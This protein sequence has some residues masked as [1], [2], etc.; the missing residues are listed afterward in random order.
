MSSGSIGTLYEKL[1]PGPGRSAPK[2]SSHQRTRIQGA[3]IEIAAERGYEAVTVRKLAE[4]AGVSTRSF[5]EHFGEKE[6]CFLSTYEWLV[7]RLARRMVRSQEAGRHWRQSLRLGLGTLIHE[8][9]A[10]PKAARLLLVEALVVGPPAAGRIAR[11]EAIF[12]AVVKA[13]LSQAPAEEMSPPFA[14]RAIVSGATRVAR[15]RL[16]EGRVEELPEL[17]DELTE[18]ALSYR[19]GPDAD[20]LGRAATPERPARSEASRQPQ[21]RGERERRRVERSP[22]DSRALILA[23]VAKLAADDG[24]EALSAPRIRATAGVSR[25]AFDAHFDGVLGCYLAAVEQ[26]STEAL[27]E[28]EHEGARAATWPA[29]LNRAVA[30]LCER[31]GRDRAFARLVFVEGTPPGLD[32]VRLRERLVAT[33]A[34]RLRRSAPAGRR[35]ALAP[36]S[37]EA[38]LSLARAG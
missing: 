28:A 23:A 33:A 32:G 7:R 11:A 16:L 8:L 18:W 2:V 19:G 15:T 27:A 30:V 1:K 3:M 17:V 31:I 20:L 26:L 34:E 5:Y 21:L 14:A 22:R 13:D 29:G 12:D 10:E 37:R 9:A 6:E 38:D 35:N 25:K 4:V 24:Y 36:P